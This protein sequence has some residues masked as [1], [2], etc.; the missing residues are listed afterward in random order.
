[1]NTSEVPL[2][3]GDHNMLEAGPPVVSPQPLK[4]YWTGCRLVPKS[5]VRVGNVL[6]MQTC[7]SLGPM[8]LDKL[9]DC[10]PV[11][12]ICHPFASDVAS[13]L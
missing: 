7:S 3:I 2:V 4:Y 8:F 12:S 13:E 10:L 1:M 5:L 9:N 6:A 11:P